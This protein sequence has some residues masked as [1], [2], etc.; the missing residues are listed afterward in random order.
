MKKKARKKE[1]GTVMTKETLV[2]RD[3]SGRIVRMPVTH[4]TRRIKVPISGRK[5]KGGSANG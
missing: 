1:A 4:T 3:A 2:M 5:P